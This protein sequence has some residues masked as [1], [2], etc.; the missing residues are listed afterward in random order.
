VVELNESIESSGE[1][2]ESGDD[3]D[4]EPDW[5]AGGESKAAKQRKLHAQQMALA[6]AA[7]SKGSKTQQA[8]KK[9]KHADIEDQKEVMTKARMA[10]LM[11]KADVFGQV[12]IRSFSLHTPCR[13]RSIQPRCTVIT[14][15]VLLCSAAVPWQERSEDQS[16]VRQ[17]PHLTLPPPPHDGAARRRSVCQAAEAG[18]AGGGHPSDDLGDDAHFHQFR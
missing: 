1:S 11:S 2:E 6:K 15:G 7:R 12:H 13:Y 14:Y 10:F 17:S 8:A 3:S 9:R 4:D 18:G 5:R 16:V